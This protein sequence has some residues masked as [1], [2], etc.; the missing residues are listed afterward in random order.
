M[1][2]GSTCWQES[3]PDNS[4]A[5]ECEA[6]DRAP[7]LE[8]QALVCSVTHNSLTGAASSAN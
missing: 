7:S 4:V 3:R 2:V 8:S 1:S 5:T 6:G